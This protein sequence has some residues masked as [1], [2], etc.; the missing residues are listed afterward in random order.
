MNR[1]AQASPRNSPAPL[2]VALPFG[3]TCP[4]YTVKT[5]WI[6]LTNPLKLVMALDGRTIRMPITGRA[7]STTLATAER[8]IPNGTSRCGFVISY[9]ALLGSSK[10]TKLNSRTPT[11]STNPLS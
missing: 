6:A 9:P 10:P 2:R 11:S 5:S 1:I 7:Y 3:L 4:P 8:A